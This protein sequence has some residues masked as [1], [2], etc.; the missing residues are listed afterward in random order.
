MII[1]IL[2]KE[3]CYVDFNT[4][5][6]TSLESGKILNFDDLLVY[7]FKKSNLYGFEVTFLDKNFKPR[8]PRDSQTFYAYSS[9][10]NKE[11]NIFKREFFR[12]AKTDFKNNARKKSRIENIIAPSVAEFTK[13]NK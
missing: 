2:S 5:K 4:R 11:Y 6:I 8:S 12:R 3:G 10:S 9:Y 7:S 13:N 1:L